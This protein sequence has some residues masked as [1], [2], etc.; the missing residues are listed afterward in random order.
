MDDINLTDYLLV[1][2]RRRFMVG[3]IAMIAALIALV[4]LLLTPY[5]YRG[6]AVLI[7]PSQEQSSALGVLSKLGISGVGDLGMS[8]SGGV[9]LYTEILKS[10]TLSEQVSRDLRLG[11]A[12]EDI[13][14]LQD[15]VDVTPTKEGALQICCYAPSSWVKNGKLKREFDGDTLERQTANLAAELTNAYIRRLQDFD[16]Q[17]SMSTSQRNRKFLEGEVVKTREELT[18]AEDTLRKF[19]ESHPA[20]PPP[21]TMSQQVEQLISL[22]TKQ[23]EAE[24][25]LRETEESAAEARGVI[26]DQEA[27]LE[28]SRVIQENPVVSQLKSRLAQAEVLR[29]KL[30]E[31]MTEKSPDVI[32]ASQEIEKIQE[33]IKSEIPKITSSE[34]MQINPVRQSLV[35]NLAQLEIKKSG[36]QARLDTLGLVLGRVEGEISSI[37]KDQMRYVRLMREAKALEAVYTS[38]LTQLSQA[39]VI[40]AKEP[41]GFTVLDWATAERFHYKPKIKLTLAASFMLGLIAGCLAALIRESS[42]PST[43]RR[44]AA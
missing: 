28:A 15:K 16:R 41:E 25:E 18:D 37:A 1:I 2:W 40:E 33:Q 34:T 42:R 13:S 9:G 43:K 32:A 23:I 22:R 30:L 8:S 39:K 35:Q 11:A 3:A 5:T 20:M 36:V 4:T 17:H 31:D 24:A 19:K 44:S 7:F 27:V 38:L 10:R 14:E 21:E 26:D 29:A 12:L 6:K